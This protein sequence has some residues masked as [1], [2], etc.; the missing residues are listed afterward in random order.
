MKKR[1]R[2]MIQSP[3]ESIEP[4]NVQVGIYAEGIEKDV[5][6]CSNDN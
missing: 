2:R 3:N 5:N 1:Y 4:D 6:T